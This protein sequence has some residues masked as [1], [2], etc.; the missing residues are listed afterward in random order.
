MFRDEHMNSYTIF[1]NAQLLERFRSLQRGGFPTDKLEERFA[2]EP[3]NALMS[4][5]Q[6]SR[7]A[8]RKR[9]SSAGEIQSATTFID[10]NLYL[11]R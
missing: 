10:D 7:S 1:Q 6:M 3:V 4:E 8:P 9:N 2:S 5:E 11:V